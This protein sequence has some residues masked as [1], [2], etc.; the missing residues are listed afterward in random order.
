M[1]LPADITVTVSLPLRLTAPPQ[2]GESV[3]VRAVFAGGTPTGVRFVA[4]R[5]LAG[6]TPIQLAG[7][8]LVEAPAGTFTAT[9]TFLASGTWAI[10]AECSGP[11]PAA[12]E[13]RLLVSPSEAIPDATAGSPLLLPGGVPV[14]STDPQAAL[15]SS[16]PEIEP[17]EPYL[18]PVI[19][20]S[21]GR[22][23]VAA[24]GQIVRRTL[25][26]ITTDDAT[27]AGAQRT[28]L[29][30]ATDAPG[31]EALAH[32]TDDGGAITYATQSWVAGLGLGAAQVPILSAIGGTATAFTATGAV[33]PGAGRTYLFAPHVTCGASPSLNVNATGAKGLRQQ[34]GG[35][36]RAQMLQ[37]GLLYLIADN[38]TNYQVQGVVGT[39]QQFGNLSVYS[40]G[41]AII[42]RVFKADGDTQPVWQCTF[43]VDGEINISTGPGGTTAPTIRQ[44]IQVDGASRFFG[45][46][47]AD[48]GTEVFSAKNPAFTY[49]NIM[50][51]TAAVAEVTN[52]RDLDP[53]VVQNAANWPFSP[54][55]ASLRRSIRVTTGGAFLNLQHMAANSSITIDTL[56]AGSNSRVYAGPD[57]TFQGQ[58]DKVLNI[59][60][61]GIYRAIKG[62]GSKI[63]LVADAGSITTGASQV[64]PSYA[65]HLVLTGQSWAQRFADHGVLGIQ[66]VFRDAGVDY[67]TWSID[68]S[69]GASAMID[70]NAT[71]ADNYYWDTVNDQPGPNLLTAK[72]TIQANPKGALVTDMIWMYGGADLG[73]LADT[74]KTT[75]ATLVATQLK[76]NAWLRGPSGLNNPNLRMWF[77]PTPSKA[78]S[79]ISPDANWY[80]MRR[81]FLEVCA[82]DPSGRSYRG[83]DYYADERVQDDEHYTF[84]AMANQGRRLARRMRNVLNG[85]SEPEGPKITSVTD[86]GGGA[87]YRVRISRGE[88]GMERPAV[89]VGFAFLPAGTDWVTPTPIFPSAFAW[90]SDGLGDYLDVTPATAGT[91]YRLCY[92]WGSMEEAAE[93]DRVIRGTGSQSPLQTYHPTV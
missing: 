66:E 10:R 82:Q 9:L 90:G 22:A 48:A 42:W 93:Y 70:G 71:I 59:A 39:H 38:G 4:R 52:A 5:N 28:R 53:W 35:Q 49:P 12:D 36:I 34:G 50:R 33:P 25:A 69:R 19:R 44:R 32:A 2:V 65:R 73:Q 87:T 54:S 83:I 63:V 23:R 15:I 62:G 85:A 29:A 55:G 8:D 72:A 74:G 37:A 58:A 41:G 77:C 56:E 31:G 60:G 20:K 3:Q 6:E 79:G 11:T 14:L 81:M 89:P 78:R 16:F 61:G 21:D 30:L 26:Q 17:T 43:N 47:L 24:N 13:L 68:A 88:T 7:V 92:P 64:L 1:P 76:I 91:G 51:W 75:F 67:S 57:F 27:P 40:S 80:P 45:K 18:A 84:K 86:Q 46:I